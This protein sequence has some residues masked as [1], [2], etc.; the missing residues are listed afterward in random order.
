MLPR[1]VYRVRFYPFWPARCTLSNCR[2][3]FDSGGSVSE[4]ATIEHIVRLTASKI[5]LEVV[6]VKRLLVYHL[7]GTGPGR[8]L[9]S[10]FL[11][12]VFDTHALG[13][14]ISLPV[15]S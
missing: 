6:R 11:Y 9:I 15:A 13:Y 3:K 7:E 4:I 14:T 12:F 10:A 1:T 2:P 8:F 5:D